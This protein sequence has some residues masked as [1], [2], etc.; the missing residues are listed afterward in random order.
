MTLFWRSFL[1]IAALLVVSVLASFQI[2]R[3]YE[4]EPRARELA[5]QTVSVVNLT[6]AALVSADPVLRRELL[7]ELNDREGI[8]IYPVTNEE[9]LV[10]LRPDGP[11]ERVAARVRAQLG[12]TTRFAAARDGMRGFWVSFFI[13]EDEF[14]V[15]LPR[16]RFEPELG[17]G[18]LGW[19]G[20]LLALA[21]LGAW[22]IAS[23]IA[24]PLAGLAEAA[25]RI[26][27]GEAPAP[28]PEGGERELRTVQ[29]AFNR[30]AGDLASMERERAMVLAG[31]SHDLRTPLS[32]LRLALEMSGAEPAAAQGMNAD[33]EEMDQVIGQFLDFARGDAE[34]REPV[35][36][37]ALADEVA[38]HFA[39]LGK[40][41]R[42]TGTSGTTVSAA[43]MALHRALMNLVD[44]ALRHAGG[45][46][47]VAAARLDGQVALEVLDRGPGIAPGEVDRLKRPFTRLDPARGGRGGAGLGLAIVERVAHAHGG[48]FELAP[49]HG[50]G[51]AAR[52]VLPAP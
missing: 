38:A 5:R 9:V 17:L 13:D 37:D 42:R 34:A 2:L 3:V 11:L 40:P 43:R 46:V 21:L 4:R 44:N 41:V 1:L 49:R 31:I 36:V 28:L 19:G 12:K 7:V 10:P 29:S 22:L 16:E 6:R 35:A 45:E 32:R 47:E 39:K 52:L 25:R 23:R 18:W 8:R 33:I 24:R 27:R 50:G 20:A 14:W 51:L 26:G 30:M 15:M 48:R